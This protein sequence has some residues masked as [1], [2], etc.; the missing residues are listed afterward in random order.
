MDLDRTT[1]RRRAFI[2]GGW[3]ACG[4]LRR[5]GAQ[6]R[7][8][9]SRRA[10]GVAWSARVGTVVVVAVVAVACARPVVGPTVQRTSSVLCDIDGP[11][12]RVEYVLDCR[13]DTGQSFATQ[14]TH[15]PD[16][17]RAESGVSFTAAE[18][19]HVDAL[20]AAGLRQICAGYTNPKLGYPSL[21]REEFGW[22]ID[23]CR[24]ERFLVI[25][26]GTKKIELRSPLVDQIAAVEKIVH[27]RELGY[28]A[29]WPQR[30][31]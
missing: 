16:G 23:R 2:A 15:Q 10:G 28:H 13:E 25:Y 9:G 4:L 26:K 31:E 3:R 14:L 21:H 6:T 24:G 7:K 5:R 27:L 17:W 19:T 11:I 1:C 30:A 29:V 18:S 12:D 22:P 20:L 8:R